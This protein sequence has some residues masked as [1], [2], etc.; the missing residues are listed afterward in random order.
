MVIWVAE[1]FELAD[2]AAPLLVTAFVQRGRA[3]HRVRLWS[4]GSS[5]YENLV[6]QRPDCLRVPVGALPAET[7]PTGAS[8]A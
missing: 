1:R 5:D 3:R 4:A 7:R 6:D 8:S 2:G